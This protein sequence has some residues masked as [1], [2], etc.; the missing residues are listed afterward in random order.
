MDQSA[1][2]AVGV[3]A[4]AFITA[5]SSLTVAFYQRRS[6]M[7]S[8]HRLRAIESHLSN[9][10]RIFTSARS[11]Q[12]SLNDFFIV[13][14]RAKST[15][16]PFLHQLL[17]I[18]T[19]RAYEY[20]V[21]VDWKHSPGMAYLEKNME[22]HCLKVRDL[23]LEWLSLQKVTSGRVAF[24]RQH[25]GYEMVPLSNI[26]LLRPGD[27]A[28]LRI[29]TRRIVKMSRSDISLG[30]SIMKELTRVITELKQMLAY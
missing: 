11:F 16:D 8:E 15:S 4:G 17:E 12:D 21:S 30:Y 23:T 2:T 9:Y 22:D 25:A 27:Y 1:I 14:R 7:R 6:L 20:C 5:I 26:S 3:V 18:V 19:A 10:E 13:L 28:E 24:V 29:E